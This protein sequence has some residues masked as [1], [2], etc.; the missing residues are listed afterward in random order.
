VGSLSSP[1][2]E[3]QL[4]VKSP[5]ARVAAAIGATPDQR[6]DIGATHDQHFIDL[7]ETSLRKE[8][9]AFVSPCDDE[10]PAH[11]GSQLPTANSG[12]PWRAAPPEDAELGKSSGM[13][14]AD[15]RV[16]AALYGHGL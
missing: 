9:D 16:L 13:Q 4:R 11:S 7:T 6:F 2:K 5:G 14:P 10:E 15:V 1:K 12:V 3:A 8:F